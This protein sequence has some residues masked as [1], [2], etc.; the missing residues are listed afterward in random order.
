MWSSV[1][2]PLPDR[3]I[4]ATISPLLISKSIFARAAIDVLE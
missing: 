3:P 2:F 1:D 4:R